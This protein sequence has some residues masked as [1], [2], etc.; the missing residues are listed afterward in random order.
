MTLARPLFSYGA[1]KLHVLVDACSMLCDRMNSLYPCSKREG[2]VLNGLLPKA[3]TKM[4]VSH[5][6][7]YEQEEGFCLAR[8]ASLYSLLSQ[9]VSQKWMWLI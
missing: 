8:R 6:M 5:H 2:L 9:A 3:F 4:D 1:S 7:G